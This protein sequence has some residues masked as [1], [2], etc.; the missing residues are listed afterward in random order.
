[1]RRSSAQA[2]IDPLQLM[3]HRALS[4]VRTSITNDEALIVTSLLGKAYQRILPPIASAMDA[5]YRDIIAVIG[6]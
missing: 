3:F 4:R 5:I 2:S 6:L 1:L